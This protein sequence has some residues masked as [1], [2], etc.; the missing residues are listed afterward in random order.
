MSQGQLEGR[1]CA[2]LRNSRYRYLNKE[3][4]G[5]REYL[6]KDDLTTQKLVF[7]SYLLPRARVQIMPTRGMSKAY[8]IIDGGGR[9]G[10][11]SA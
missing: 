1:F 11:N 3:I 5:W 8:G 6:T 2:A 4:V 10:N 9:K 7:N